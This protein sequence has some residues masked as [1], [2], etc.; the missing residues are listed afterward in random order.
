MRESHNFLFSY[1]INNGKDGLHLALS[2]DGLMWKALNRGKAIIRPQVGKNNLMRD[3]CLILGQDDIFHMVWT[4]GWR[5]RGIGLAHSKDLITWSTQE[6]I[7]VMQHEPDALNCWAPELF[8][9]GGTEQYLIFWSTT[10]PGRFP[11]TEKGGDREKGH[12]LNHRIYYTTT[13]DFSH[14]T[15]TKLLYDDKF[16]AIDATLIKF[17][18]KY[19]M[20]VKDETRHPVAKNLRISIADAAEGPYSSASKPF[21]PSWVEGP[22]V[23]KHDDGWYVYFDQYLKGGYGCYYTKDFQKWQDLSRKLILPRNVHHGFALGVPP[24]TIRKLLEVFPLKKQRKWKNWI[25]RAKS[26]E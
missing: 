1:F 9:D 20:V 12:I 23:L 6:Y 3:P 8:Y 22:S 18:K 13:A 4:T 25:K 26:P 21:T 7:P 5:D 10:I 24:A 11:K 16:N 19:L 17:G 2:H 15:E 14:F